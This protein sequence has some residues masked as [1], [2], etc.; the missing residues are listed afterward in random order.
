[1]ERQF[2]KTGHVLDVRAWN[3]STFYE[4]DLHLPGVDMQKWQSVQHMKVKVA[5]YTYRDYTPAQWDAL[6]NTCTLYIDAAHDGS[7]SL[8]ASTLRAGNEIMYMGIS[9]AFTKP[10]N[11][12]ALFCLGDS[13]AIGH[14]LA[15]EQLAG[16]GR[17]SGAIVIPD[18]DHR[19][20]FRKDF[21]SGLV[22]IPQQN[23]DNID[24]LHS[25]LQEQQFDDGAVYLAGNVPM[26]VELRKKIKS[27]S[28]FKGLVKVQG[29]WW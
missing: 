7:G 22:A 24:N 23:S 26:V 25:W 16:K 20:F 9:S 13:S 1:M 17:L 28:G 18:P 2:A 5:E 4:I 3:P 11:A 21:D 14:F 15:L 29:F 12:A 10:L 6:T 19:D 27:M 8:W